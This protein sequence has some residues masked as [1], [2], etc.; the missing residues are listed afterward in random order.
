MSKTERDRLDRIVRRAG[1]IIGSELETVDSIYQSL[2]KRS[3]ASVLGDANHPLRSQV[4]QRVST[5]NPNR[6]ILPTLTTNR[7]RDF[8]TIRAI[9]MN[10]ASVAKR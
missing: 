2:V 5:L 3:L 6:L 8:F 1:R 9:K 4:I 7:Y 10:N